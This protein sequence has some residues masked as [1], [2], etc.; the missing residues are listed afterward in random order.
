MGELRVRRRPGRPGHPG[1]D[2]AHLGVRLDGRARPA[3]HPAWTGQLA[4]PEYCGAHVSAP[5]SGQTG[6]HLPL[7]LRA[8]TALFGHFGIEWD[9]TAADEASLAELAGWI[10][11]Y[12]THR[13]LLHSGRVVRLDVPDDAML[14]HGVVAADRSAALMSYVQLGESGHTRSA[15]LRVPGLEPARAYRVTDVTPG[16]GPD[17][18]GGG[19]DAGAGPDA[20]EGPDASSAMAGPG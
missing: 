13:P 8:A 2:P 19:P 6:R 17:A 5:V 11:L 12:K 14:I 9:L 1:A 16:S 7:A 18:G 20:G 15:A 3:G 10:R 4:P